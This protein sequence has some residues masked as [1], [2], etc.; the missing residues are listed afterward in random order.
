LFW[1][2]KIKVRDEKEKISL[3]IIFVSTL[4]SFR[5]STYV[6][7]FIYRKTKTAI[8]SQFQKRGIQTLSKM[9]KAM[10]NPKRKGT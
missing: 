6:F 1:G 3:K 7:T 2:E 4:F 8:G 5:S 10:A 9:E